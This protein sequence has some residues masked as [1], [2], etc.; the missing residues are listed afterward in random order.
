MEKKLTTGFWFVIA[1]AILL[2]QCGVEGF[3]VFSGNETLLESVYGIADSA[4]SPNALMVGLTLIHG[5]A[6]KGAG[7]FSLSL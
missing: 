7:I 6:A 2:S 5:A 3:E 1:A 4:S